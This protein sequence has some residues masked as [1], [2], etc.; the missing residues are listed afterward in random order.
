MTLFIPDVIAAVKLPR[1]WVM[2]QKVRRICLHEQ[3]TPGQAAGGTRD[4]G[5]GE[6]R[7]WWRK[8]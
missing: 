5:G 3:R 6:G 4:K 1:S 8:W 7:D 2:S